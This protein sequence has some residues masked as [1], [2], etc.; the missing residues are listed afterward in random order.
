MKAHEI[1]EL[2]VEEITTRI[3]EWEKELFRARC[4]QSTGQ[5]QNT[6]S[7]RDLRRDIARAKT[8]F[9]EKRNA[10]DEPGK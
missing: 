5:L 1:R 10:A 2:S 7:L 6:I 9:S 3:A 4:S 8:I